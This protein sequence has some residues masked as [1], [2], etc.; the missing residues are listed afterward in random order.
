MRSIHPGG[1]AMFA[2]PGLF[3]TLINPAVKLPK[4]KSPLPARPD[5][6]RAMPVQFMAV[7]ENQIALKNALKWPGTICRASSHVQTRRAAPAPAVEA[8]QRHPDPLIE[9]QNRRFASSLFP[10]SQAVTP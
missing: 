9:R 8:V 6:R 4:P 2:L 1:A 7:A 10:A 3:S 5:P